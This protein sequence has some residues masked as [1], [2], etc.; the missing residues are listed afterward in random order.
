MRLRKVL[1]LLLCVLLLP[2]TA[3]T[4]EAETEQRDRLIESMNL[5]ELLAMESA[6][7][8]PEET[9]RA[10]E[11]I[12]AFGFELPAETAFK[13]VIMLN[14]AEAEQEETIWFTGVMDEQKN[15]LVYFDV[16]LDGKGRPTRVSC[17]SMS[18]PSAA[19]AAAAMTE[20][21]K[22][23]CY[24]AALDAALKAMIE[25]HGYTTDDCFYMDVSRV[26]YVGMNNDTEEWYQLIGLRGDG[27]RPYDNVLIEYCWRP[28]ADRMCDVL[29]HY[30][31]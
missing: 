9:A 19:S 1:V 29:L 10:I 7:L 30:V 18:D 3:T 8:A 5:D 2:M 20:E 13:Q 15:E 14:E 26:R 6:T 22:Q 17:Y 24:E 16:T 4:A 31:Q 23:A 25:D 28:G 12:R 11:V 27:S 21:E